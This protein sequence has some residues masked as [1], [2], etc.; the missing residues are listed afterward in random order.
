[1]KS[2]KPVLLKIKDVLLKVINILKKYLLKLYTLVKSMFSE[3]VATS[4]QTNSIKKK[5]FMNI[6]FII[7]I[8]V[9]LMGTVSAYMS[10]KITFDTLGQTMDD[11]AVASSDIVTQKLEIY[12]TIA[13]DI[14]LISELS[15]SLVSS[16]IKTKIYKQIIEM[17]KLSDIYIVN[18]KGASLSNTTGRIDLVGDTDY[19]KASMNGETFVTNPQIS[20]QTGELV[21]IASAPLWKD[22]IYGSTIE[23]VVV[24]EVDGKMLSDIS[25]S[26]KIGK[27]GYGYII[28][29]DGYTIG[30]PDYES[31]KN[32]E[33]VIQ[34]SEKNKKL[35]GLANLEK[36]ALSGKPVF[37]TYK[38]N[39]TK[40]LLASAS[41]KGSNGWAIF[42]NAPQSEYMG[43]MIFSIIV[44]ALLGFIAILISIFSARRMSNS[45]AEPIVACANRLKLLSEGDLHTEVPKTDSK[46]ETGMLLSSMEATVNELNDVIGD[47]SFHLGAIADGDYTTD[48][49][50]EY[51]GDLVPIENSLKKII[52]SLNE[53]SGQIDESAEQLSTSSEQ[54]AC[55]AQA[56]SQ[57]STEQ[58]SSVE[59]LAA[60]INQM[61]EQIKL[62]AESAENAKNITFDASKEVQNGNEQIVKMTK[63]MNEIN[64]TSLQIGKI[65]KTIEDIAFQTNLLALNAAIEAARAGEAGKGFAVVADEV[66][67]LAAKSSE[68]AQNTTDLI[69]GALRAVENGDVI[70][71]NTAESLKRIVEKTEMTVSIVEKIAE[72]TQQQSVGASQITSGIEQIASVVQHNSATAEES[73]AAS[74]ELS[75]Q[76]QVLKK[77]LEGIKLKGSKEL[78]ESEEFF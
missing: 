59:E 69:E 62:N 44:T 53:L 25:S 45:I 49:S 32:R 4:K 20:I 42:V 3:L 24:V 72:A 58:A 8:V 60:T 40:K 78:S 6:V 77:L 39:G 26:V 13:A 22:G 65:I 46:D 57:G 50:K 52:D 73:A 9:V 71:E 75:I 33:N 30:H 18:K 2:M 38:Y 19:F 11:L 7:L 66:R 51:L 1:M 48:V 28:D 61:T 17:H 35:R 67:N 70:V 47:I 10:N 16:E 36:K 74:Q 27:G 21:V 34:N 55:G 56:L 37:G 41:V 43:S 23:G 54:V 12:K 76:A 5:I 15:S 29:K 63:A 14:G 68:A 64:E 31:V